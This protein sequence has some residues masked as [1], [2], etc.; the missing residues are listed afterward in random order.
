MHVGVGRGCL[1]ARQAEFDA[2]VVEPSLFPTR[3]HVRFVHFDHQ[4][5]YLRQ[6]EGQG[7]RRD[8]KDKLL[9]TRLRFKVDRK[10]LPQM[11]Q[12][13]QAEQKDDDADGGDNDHGQEGEKVQ[14]GARVVQHANAQRRVAFDLK[15]Q[16]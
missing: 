6:N 4:A 9:E 16:Q 12:T 15:Q 2:V 7:K 3:L 14:R 10:A 11:H 5:V 8:A 1:G 13:A